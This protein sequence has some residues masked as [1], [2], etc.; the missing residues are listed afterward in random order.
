M[1]GW[2]TTLTY[3]AGVT[4]PQSWNSTLSAA[5]P[6]FTFTNAAW[7]GAI[8]AGSSA[9]TSQRASRAC[10]AG[11]GWTPS[12]RTS[13]RLQRSPSGSRKVASSSSAATAMASLI[14]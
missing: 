12:G 7:N 3:P 4:V 5:P 9:V 1:T 10:P 6:V 13:R 8:P 14:R 11:V 2:K